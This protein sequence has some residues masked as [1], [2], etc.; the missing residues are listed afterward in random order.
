MSFAQG[1]QI[2]R[3]ARRG[4]SGGAT[5]RRGGSTTSIVM[6]SASA[7]PEVRK[8]STLMSCLGSN[9]LPPHR[10]LRERRTGPTPE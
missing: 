9:T 3:D 2:P 6:P 8:P 5:L 7:S 1:A 10:A 4:V